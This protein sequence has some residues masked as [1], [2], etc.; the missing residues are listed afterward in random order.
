M[1]IDD[2]EPDTRSAPAWAAAAH[3]V[4]DLALAQNIADQFGAAACLRV[5]A[6]T[7]WKISDALEEQNQ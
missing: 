3:A 7:A 6:V 5:L 1:N 2:L 4:A